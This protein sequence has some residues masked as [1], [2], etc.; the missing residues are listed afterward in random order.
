MNIV[1]TFLPK[2][3]SE[4]GGRSSLLK[5]MKRIL[6]SLRLAFALRESSDS[7][8][9][10][11]LTVAGVW[12]WGSILP[13]DIASWL[14]CM[15]M[16]PVSL[17]KLVSSARSPGLGNVVWLCAGVGISENIWRLGDRISS[18]VKEWSGASST[19]FTLS[20]GVP[21]KISS[22]SVRNIEKTGA[23]IFRVGAKTIPTF[24][25]VILLTSELLT[26]TIKNWTNARSKARFG[27]GSLWTKELKAA[28][29]FCFSLKSAVD[30][31]ISSLLI[32]VQYQVMYL[33]R[34]RKNSM[35][36][37]RVR[38]VDGSSRRYCL[39]NDATA[40]TS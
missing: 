28:I 38:T 24:L 1:D 30:N 39:N 4:E 35:C 17:C 8:P 6:L 31:S 18:G 14:G 40:C 27:F 20:S 34:T 2:L 25:T 26:M 13:R 16:K 37:S 10:I 21:S 9:S 19:V 3:L 11:L 7:G 15:G 23:G 36:K 32:N 33:P 5:S 12:P 29:F 22:K